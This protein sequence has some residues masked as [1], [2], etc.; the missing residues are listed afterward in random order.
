MSKKIVSAVRILVAGLLF[1]LTIPSLSTAKSVSPDFVELAKKLTPTVVN[2]RTAKV[3]KPKQRM[4]RPRMQS[5]FD[6]FFDDFFGQLDQMPQQRPRREQ[7][8]G[9]GFIISPDG[10]ILT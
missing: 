5:P 4:Q 6:N 3:I 2:I 7:S 10:Y 8:L 1:T 9:T